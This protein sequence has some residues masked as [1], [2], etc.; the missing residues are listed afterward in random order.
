MSPRLPALKPAQVIAALQKAGFYVVRDTGKHT[1]MYRSGLARPFPV[2]RHNKD[3][4]RGT[5][6]GII[7]QAGLTPEG[8]SRYL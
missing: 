2:P 3:L 5:L 6:L 7:K 8:F 1:I 4:K